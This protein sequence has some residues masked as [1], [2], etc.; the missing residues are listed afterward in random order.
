MNADLPARQPHT[1]QPATRR[2][3]ALARWLLPVSSLVVLAGYLG[4]WVPHQAAGLVVTGLDLAEYVKF[5]HPVRSGEVTVWREGFYLPLVVVSMVLSLIAYRQEFGYSWPI[6]LGLLL[7]ASIGALNLLPP[8][9]SPALLMAAEF[10]LQSAAMVLCLAMA[11]MSPCLALIPRRPMIGISFGLG[12]AALFLPV[13]NFIKIL[14][15]L[16]VLYNHTILAGWGV[17]AMAI[18]LAGMLASVASLWNWEKLT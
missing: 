6:R 10:R 9:W 3:Q 12:L 11:A 1:I 14:P 15:L 2:P 7:L 17:W 18:G 16:E 8:A 5:L 4:A 13:A